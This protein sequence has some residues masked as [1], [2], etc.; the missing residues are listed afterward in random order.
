MKKWQK[1]GLLLTVAVAGLVV[2]LLT[3]ESRGNDYGLVEEK[4]A[5]IRFSKPSG[6]YDDPFYLKIK[7]PSTEIYYTLDGSEPTRESLHYTQPIYIGDATENPNVLSERTDISCENVIVPDRKIDKCTVVRVRYYDA[8]SAS[9]VVTASFFVGYNGREG[10]GSTP[11]VSLVTDPKGLFDDAQGIY[12]L[13]DSYGTSADVQDI[14]WTGNYYNRGREWE[15][16][17]NLEYF[18]PRGKILYASPCGIRIRG[19]YSR[20]DPQKSFNLFARKEY[21]GTSTF[22]YDFWGT[23]YYPDVMSLNSGGNDHVGMIRNRMVSD[24]TKDQCFSTMNYVRCHVFLNGEYWGA[25]DLSEKYNAKYISYYY[26][27]TRRNVESVRNWQMEDGISD[28]DFA[29]LV[30]FIQFADMTLEKNYRKCWELIDKQSMLEYYATMIYCA[31][32]EDWPMDN[33]Q[34]WRVKEQEDSPYGDTKWRYMLFDM[35]SPGLTAD[36][37]SHDTIASV[38]EI[39]DFFRSLCQRP[40]FREELGAE[41][42]RIGTEVLSADRVNEYIDVCQS[43]MVVPMKLQLARYYNADETLFLEATEDTR[44]FFNNRLEAIREILRAYDMLPEIMP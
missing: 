4:N 2:A 34:F 26:G 27:V 30:S 25:Y 5:L 38:M 19:N 3:P 8:V 39:S 35:D 15:R 7:A 22:R 20:R 28:M 11:V 41:I 14:S 43:Q 33:E 17:A 24:L 40:D 23:G 21:G 31:R 1:A 6:F 32:H 42:L 9:P 18:D 29:E 16:A 36:C 44:V 37:I 12:V 13:G 10:Y